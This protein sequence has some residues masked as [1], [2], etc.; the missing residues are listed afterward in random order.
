MKMIVILMVILSAANSVAA[1]NQVKECQ[2]G[3]AW[4]VNTDRQM[5]E[6]EQITTQTGGIVVISQRE[7]PGTQK[8]VFRR[9]NLPPGTEV[10]IG[11]PVPWVKKCGNALIQTEGWLLPTPYRLQGPPGPQGLPG[12]PGIQGPAGPQ[13]PQGI[14]GP[15]GPQGP[16]AFVPPPKRS[17]KW[18]WIVAGGVAGAV[19]TA[20][21]LRGRD[22]D[23]PYKNPVI[24]IRTGP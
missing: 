18:P 19:I 12:E 20:L 8:I 2:L 15:T 23:E 9:C 16:K 13:G 6:D 4:A 5:A 7:A 3:S 17:K 1:D 22:D 10:V 24:I 21:I 14:Q 11:G